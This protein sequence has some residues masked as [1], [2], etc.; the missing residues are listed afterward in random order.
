MNLNA[1]KL[2]EYTRHTRL[3]A[4]DDSLHRYIAISAV[5]CLVDQ[6]VLAGLLIRYNQPCIISRI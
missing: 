5:A 6:Q 2:A 4:T 1:K 3:A